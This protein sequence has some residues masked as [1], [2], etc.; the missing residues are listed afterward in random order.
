MNNWS[1]TQY[2]N[3][4]ADASKDKHDSIRYLDVDT[5]TNYIALK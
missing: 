1:A 4:R 2:T 5:T 3:I